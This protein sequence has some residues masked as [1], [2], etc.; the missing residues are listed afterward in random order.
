MIRE[1]AE[2]FGI[3]TQDNNFRGTSY[4]FQN[5]WAMGRGGGCFWKRQK[6]LD[7]AN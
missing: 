7:D 6:I 4:I 2:T 5:F 1:T 3:I